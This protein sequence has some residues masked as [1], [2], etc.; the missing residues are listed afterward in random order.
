VTTRADVTASGTPAD[1]PSDGPKL[2]ANGQAVVFQSAS[3]NL[4]PGGI[5]NTTDIF[6]RDLVS[7]P[8]AWKT[9][10]PYAVGTLVTFNSVTYECVQA[11]TSQADRA[12]SIAAS[13]WRIPAPCG[14]QPWVNRARYLV[15]SLVTFGSQKYR[16]I[17]EHTAQ[18]D[19]TPPAVPTLW[20]VVS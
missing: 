20:V 9:A 15:G 11:H 4:P 12:P 17:Q 5:C 19:W 8:V 14:V 3:R 1:G 2:S 10:T 18:S 13:L 7:P 16:C 6:V